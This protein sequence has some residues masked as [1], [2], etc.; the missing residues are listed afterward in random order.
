MPVS[1]ER[2]ILSA[3]GRAALFSLAAKAAIV[4]RDLALAMR[5]GRGDQVDVYLAAM[6]LPLLVVQ[7]VAAS[8]ATNLSPAY[9]EAREKRGAAAAASLVARGTAVVLA[10]LG[11]SVVLLWLAAPLVMQAVAPGFGDEKLHMARLLLQWLAPTVMFQGMSIVWTTLLNAEG[12]FGW[13]SLVPAATP[14]LLVALLL[15]WDVDIVT[16]AMATLGGA[17][18]EAGLCAVALRRTGLPLPRWSGVA[19]L[20]GLIVESVHLGIG[21]AMMTG[22]ALIDQLFASLAGPGAVST[23]SY[24]GKISS[25]LM[26][27]A[28]SALAVAVLPFFSEQVARRDAVGLR[29]S[30]HYWEKRILLISIPLTLVLVAACE[31][32]VRAIFERGHF[33][34]AD[35]AAVTAVQRLALL[36]I[37]FFLLGTVNGRMLSALS[38]NR[39][40]VRIAAINFVMNAVLDYTFLKLFGLPGIALST[41]VVYAG[42]CTLSSWYLRRT[43]RATADFSASG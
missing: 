28:A 9:I 2:R 20:R 10:V 15:G 30:L 7:V 4:G 6:A 34:A 26:A 21:Q 32:M 22:G 16:V 27:S 33:A 11:V 8:C 19:G 13:I 40:V 38:R 25:F 17:A 29:R 23:L 31:P 36:Q 39:M 43:L 24:G 1:I 3:A 12:R 5:F 41:A 35:T 37:P 18:I 42:S 14:V